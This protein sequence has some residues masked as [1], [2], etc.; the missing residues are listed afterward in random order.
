MLSVTSEVRPISSRGRGARASQ[1]F[2]TVDFMPYMID[3]TQSICRTPYKPEISVSLSQ[4]S[5]PIVL[6]LFYS[7]VFITLLLFI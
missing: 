4:N 2:Y 5:C 6:W 1:K 7:F 3:H